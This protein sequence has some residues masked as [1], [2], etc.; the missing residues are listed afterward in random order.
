MIRTGIKGVELRNI[1]AQ[2][3]R[4]D[5]LSTLPLQLK[6]NALFSFLLFSLLQALQIKK[7]LE[8]RAVAQKL[9]KPKSFF[10]REIMPFFSNTYYSD[11]DESDNDNANNAAKEKFRQLKEK[12]KQESELKNAIVEKAR[13][14]KEALNRA[15]KES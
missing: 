12:R 5:R 8:E 2:R 9:I 4:I 10:Q 11:S 15:V 6:F 3:V 13:L 1:L 14:K 7:R